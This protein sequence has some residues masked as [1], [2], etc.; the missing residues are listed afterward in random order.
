[1]APLLFAAKGLRSAVCPP[2]GQARPTPPDAAQRSHLGLMASA[3]QTRANGIS[4]RL[5]H[6]SA[7]LDAGG[8]DVVQ[9]SRFPAQN[10]DA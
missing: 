5:A 6:V 9:R 1:M 8:A 7:R 3:L 10:S 2:A 4:P